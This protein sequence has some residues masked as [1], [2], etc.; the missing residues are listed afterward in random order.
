MLALGSAGTDDEVS[1]DYPTVIAGDD[2]YSMW[3]SALDN[4]ETGEYRV[5][6]ASAPFGPILFVLMAQRSYPH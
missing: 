6:Y 4:G 3:Y 2:G 1:A 5:A